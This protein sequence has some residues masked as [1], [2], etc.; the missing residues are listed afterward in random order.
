MTEI[1]MS[2][3]THIVAAGQVALAGIYYYC[4]LLPSRVLHLQQ[5]PQQVLVLF[6]EE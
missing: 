6:L 5:A 3:I 1:A 2:V 4:P